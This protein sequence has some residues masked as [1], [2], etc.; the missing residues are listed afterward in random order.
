MPHL[1][2]ARSSKAPFQLA[3]VLSFV[4][5][6]A[7]STVAKDMKPGITAWEAVGESLTQVVEEGSKLLP[8]V[9]EPENVLSSEQSIFPSCQG[10]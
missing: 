2:D 9:M 4:K 3:T 10:H 6:I 7:S 8:M 5:Q 1:S